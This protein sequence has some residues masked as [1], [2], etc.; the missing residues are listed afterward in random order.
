MKSIL[1]KSFLEE[2][3]LTDEFFAWFRLVL[4]HSNYKRQFWLWNFWSRLK[5]A[6]AHFAPL[7]CAKIVNSINCPNSLFDFNF[8][9]I[10]ISDLPSMAIEKVFIYNNT[11]IIQDEIL[12]HRL[13]LIPLKADPRLFQMKPSSLSVEGL[14]NFTYYPIFLTIYLELKV[15]LQ[16]LTKY[17]GIWWKKKK[18]T[19]ISN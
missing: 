9:F 1:K 13:G 12:S 11:S 2:T 6:P 14:S 8:L 7:H 3:L 16:F 10:F 17:H 4:H 15:K 5:M 19:L 18:L